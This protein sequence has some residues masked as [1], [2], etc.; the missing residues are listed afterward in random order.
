MVKP[1][2]EVE[3]SVLQIE[4]SIDAIRFI[5]SHHSGKQVTVLNNQLGEGTWEQVLSTHKNISELKLPI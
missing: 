1:H 5:L 4:D 3:G 2:R